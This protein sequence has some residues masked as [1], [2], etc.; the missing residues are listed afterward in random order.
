MSDNENITIPRYLV[1]T[2][3]PKGY[4]SRFYE[5]VQASGFSHVAAFEAIEGERE[6]FELPPGY[7]NYQSFK[8]C[9]SY[10]MGNRLVR[11]AE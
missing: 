8:R 6:Q 10:H 9:K 7:D 2:L 1:C 11:I 3:T 4:L 5:I